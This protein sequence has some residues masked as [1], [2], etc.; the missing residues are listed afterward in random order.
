MSKVEAS[1]RSLKAGEHYGA[2]FHKRRTD[3]AVFSESVYD[4][5]MCFPEHSHELGFFTLI[6]DGHYS[7]TRIR[8]SV[9]YSPGTVLWRGAGSSHRDRIETPSSR[10]FFAEI[11]LTLSEH[12]RQCERLPE[13]FAEQNGSLAWLASR[14]RAETRV[15]D[16]SSLI[17]D[18]LTLEMLGLLLRQATSFE[19]QI[20]KWLNRVID[21]LNDEFTE[22]LSSDSLARDAGVHPVYLAAA[23]RKFRHETIGDY[24]QKRRV[25]RACGLLHDRDLPLTDI[26]SA[27]G[28]ADQSHFT[29]IFKR[30]MLMTPGAYRNS[31]PI[32]AQRRVG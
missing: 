9:L 13:H 22:P 31:L 28:F 32:P 5:S 30:R 2:V 12:L 25:E 6:I 3:V 4:N 10:F 24:V 7:E 19:G 21:R 27:C 18:G 20:P 1:L 17:I 26:A 14:L 15:S 11:D 8:K 16:P 23:F 29:R